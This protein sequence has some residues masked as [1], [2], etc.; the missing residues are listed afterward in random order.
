[1]TLNAREPVAGGPL[2]RMSY[3]H[4]ILDA[5]AVAAQAAIA[6][7]N[8]TRHTYYCG[9]HLGSGFHEDGVVSARQVARRMGVLS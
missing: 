4:P 9:A 6:A 8:G 3:A 5:P 1:V 7:L 2:A